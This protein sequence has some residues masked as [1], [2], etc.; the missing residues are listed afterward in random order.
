MSVA[1]IVHVYLANDT[2]HNH[3]SMWHQRLGH[4]DH[5]VLF[6][7]WWAKH[8]AMLL[9]QR[10]RPSNESANK[11]ASPS[12]SRSWPSFLRWCSLLYQHICQRTIFMCFVISW[13]RYQASI[14]GCT[15]TMQ[16]KRGRVIYHGRLSSEAIEWMNACSR[17]SNSRYDQPV[18]GLIIVLS[19]FVNTEPDS[20]ISAQARAQVVSCSPTCTLSHC[21]SH[22]KD[23]ISQCSSDDVGGKDYSC[24][25][26]CVQAS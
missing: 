6:T 20:I 16:Q 9:S 25:S 26:N 12:A 21:W 23:S 7:T 24:L 8:R 18:F 15:L 1:A 14:C 19:E 10:R 17:K 4:L 3:N 2:P 22:Y 11:Q 13:L 5:R